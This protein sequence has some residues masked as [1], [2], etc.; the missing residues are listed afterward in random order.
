ME[1][2]FLFLFLK[3]TFKCINYKNEK[4]YDFHKN[5]LKHFGNG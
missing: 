1:N 2:R 4:E 5:E 3:K